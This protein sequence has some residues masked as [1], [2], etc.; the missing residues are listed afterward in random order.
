M[1]A[2][3]GGTRAAVAEYREAEGMR[4]KK[5][6]EEAA[7]PVDRTVSSTHGAAEP[8]TSPSDAP[9]A[10]G[11]TGASPAIVEG[12]DSSTIMAISS[13][14]QV[15]MRTGAPGLTFEERF[16]MASAN[17][18]DLEAV[19][20]QVKEGITTLLQHAASQTAEAHQ[21]F[22]SALAAA[23]SAVGVDGGLQ[24]SPPEALPSEDVSCGTQTSSSL[25]S[26]HYRS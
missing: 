17:S 8:D 20:E 24:S 6:E 11:Q 2:V 16:K 19:Q 5:S 21:L 10:P 26:K 3:A 9:P 14:G 4:R 23:A 18:M 7:A 13:G 15:L 12:L 22:S 25:H 1:F